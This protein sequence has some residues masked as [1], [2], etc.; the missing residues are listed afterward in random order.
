MAFLNEYQ[1]SSF[2]SLLRS[3]FPELVPRLETKGASVSLVHG[4]TICSLNYR[5]GVLLDNLSQG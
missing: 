3:D 2:V 5:D 4:T 1:G